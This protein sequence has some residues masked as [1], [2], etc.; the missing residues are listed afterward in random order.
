[1]AN[2]FRPSKG[3]RV[4]L[5]A[6]PSSSTRSGCGTIAFLSGGLRYAATTGYYLRA[7]RAESE[8]DIRLETHTDSQ[9]VWS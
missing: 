4:L 8:N 3:L 9:I 6:R 5:V 2:G 7:L 1:M